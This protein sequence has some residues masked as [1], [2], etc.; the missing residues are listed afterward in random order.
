[1]PAV[2]HYAKFTPVKPK[3]IY[4]RP[5]RSL[6]D[7]LKRVVACVDKG[8]IE[9]ISDRNCLQKSTQ[10]ITAREPAAAQGQ[11]VK[12]IK[13]CPESF[14]QSRTTPPIASAPQLQTRPPTPLESRFE[15]SYPQRIKLGVAA[16]L[17]LFA[18]LFWA[19]RSMAL[20]WTEEHQLMRQKVAWHEAAVLGRRI[21]E[22]NQQADTVAQRAA[23]QEQYDSDMRQGIA[24]NDRISAEGK[25]EAATA[26]RDRLFRETG[27]LQRKLRELNEEIVSLQTE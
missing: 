24:P 8:E 2:L 12:V 10:P 20:G 11:C 13:L 17:L 14:S 4:V 27:E 7:L 25:A 19:W 5:K 26:D 21:V 16:A 18:G 22:L 6:D 3:P 15:V 1:M 23:T 9:L